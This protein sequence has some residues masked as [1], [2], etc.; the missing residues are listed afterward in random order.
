MT[1]AKDQVVWNYAAANGLMI[2]SKD[3]GFYQRSLVYGHPPKIAWIKLG[4]C[5]TATIAAFLRRR[6]M[7]VKRFAE[8]SQASFL[9]LG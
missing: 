4:N 3:S 2:V 5:P 9:V 6:F 1:S 8:D 7:E